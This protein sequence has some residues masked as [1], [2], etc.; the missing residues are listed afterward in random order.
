MIVRESGPRQA[1]VFNAAI[2]D[3]HE[4]SPPLLETGFTAD[5]TAGVEPAG[6]FARV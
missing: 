6:A 4:L 2:Q 1:F 5:R 3:R